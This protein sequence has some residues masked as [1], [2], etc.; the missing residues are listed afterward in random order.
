MHSSTM[1][2][3]AGRLS[4]VTQ[5]VIHFLRDHRQRRSDPTAQQTV[6]R[7]QQNPAMSALQLT[8]NDER[9]WRLKTVLDENVPSKLREL[10]KSA[11]REKYRITWGDNSKSEN[12][13]M[14]MVPRSKKI[15]QHVPVI[16]G[17][18]TSEECATL[19]YCILGLKCRCQMQ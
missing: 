9:F 2:L 18:G 7:I 19:Y 1:R 6:I 4:H 8:E 16:V 13:F 12:F 5:T 15:D 3:T 11:F 10:F 17:Q 14:A